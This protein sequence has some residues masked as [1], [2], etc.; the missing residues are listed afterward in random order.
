MKK[1][2]TYILIT[3]FLFS[4]SQEQGSLQSTLNGSYAKLLTVGN[5]LYAIND[6]ELTT[7]DISMPDNPIEVNKQDVGFTI[8]NIYYSNSVL[9]IGSPEALHIFSIGLNGVPQRR[10]ETQ[11]FEFEGSCP[12]DPV[13]VQGDFAYVT[14]NTL[15]IDDGDCFRTINE[16]RIYDISNIESPKLLSTTSLN[17]PKGLAIDNDYLFVCEAYTGIKILNIADSNNPIEL[18]SLTEFESYD[19]IA[20][21]GLLMVVGPKEIRQFDYTD[22]ENV[23]FLSSIDL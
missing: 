14:L 1:A 18:T 22:I 15:S 7:I 17:Y 23:I 4:C 12:S 11:Y 13:I 20:N 9:F 8:E 21:K 6:E 2:L 19:V 3:G 10:N 5:Y 16:L